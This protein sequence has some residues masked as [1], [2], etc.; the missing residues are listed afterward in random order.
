MA[1]LAEAEGRLLRRAAG[2]LGAGLVLMAV[3]GV[4][5]L[6]GLLALLWALHRWLVALWGPGGAALA[7][8]AAALALAGLLAWQARRLVR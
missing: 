1:E 4:L 6:L 5:G 7:T 2:R 3:A 8:G